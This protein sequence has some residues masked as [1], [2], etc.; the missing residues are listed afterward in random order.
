MRVSRSWQEIL[1]GVRR[2]QGGRDGL[3]AVVYACAPLQWIDERPSAPTWM[4]G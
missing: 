1:E 2:E 4:V 3:R